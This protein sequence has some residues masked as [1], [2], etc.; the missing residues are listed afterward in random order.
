[1]KEYEGLFSLA[2]L[3]AMLAVLDSLLESF[4]KWKQLSEAIIQE[5]SLFKKHLN[6]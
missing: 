5:A 1:M 2:V 4:P 6:I 3:K